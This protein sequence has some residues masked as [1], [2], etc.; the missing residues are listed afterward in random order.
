MGV[1]FEAEQESLGRRVALK[2]LSSRAIVDEKQ[3][4]RFEREAKSAA[5]LHHTNI[6]P[7]FGVGHQDGHHYYVMQFIQGHSLDV[8]LEE[9][10]KLK[11]AKSPC[12]T[13][14]KLD[15]GR[16]DR[17]GQRRIAAGSK[18]PCRTTRPRR[19]PALPIRFS[20]AS[21]SPNQPAGPEVTSP[22]G[23]RSC[24]PGGG[25]ASP[26]RRAGGKPQRPSA[27]KPFARRPLCRR[28]PSPDF[29]P[30]AQPFRS[31]ERSTLSEQDRH[32]YQGVARVGL[33]VAEALDY[34]NN[35]GIV[36]RD[37]KPSNLLLDTKGNV[38]VTDFGLAKASDAEDLTHTG[39]ILG[40]IRYMA[41]E[42][43]Q[44]Q[45][46]ARSDI[47]SL[48]LTL[49][50]LA[51]MQ[52]AYDGSE[53]HKLMDRVLHEE[54]VRLKKLAPTSSSR[55]G[56]NHPEGNRSRPRATLPERRRAGRGL[57]SAS[58]TTNPSRPAMQRPPRRSFAGAAATRPSP[59]SRPG[60]CC[61]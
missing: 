42:R 4:R 32:F 29:D 2:V 6:V 33:Q 37:I 34:A 45:C 11:K 39:D 30:V 3:I 22:A 54:P 40:T 35:Q 25:I 12:T 50:E 28:T 26:G 53:R 16:S 46:D 9:L 59:R 15:E 44:G 38:W 8:V 19:R 52:P 13:L 60:C 49:Y 5:R 23:E 21:S 57:C 24:H 61:C 31:G 36:H 7:V 1:V 10:R 55:S 58:S 18:R 47:Y 41:P 51:S 20:P 27:G 17:P 43:F 48:G 56:D 14:A